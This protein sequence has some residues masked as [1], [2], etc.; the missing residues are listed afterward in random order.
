[1][2]L[3]DAREG[4]YSHSAK[5]SDV[6]RQLAFAGIAIVWIYKKD[7][8][9]TPTIDGSFIPATRWLICALGADLLQYVSASIAWGVFARWKEKQ[10]GVDE[11]TEFSAPPLL[12]WPGIVFF[13]M[14][15][16]CLLIA[17]VALSGQLWGVFHGTE[18][19][20]ATNGGAAATTS[21][22]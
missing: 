15:L 16:A 8:H 14:K 1:M 5:A 21:V 10:V 12:N 6:A 20:P 17:Y 3:S 18:K 19:A 22:H 2:K 4:Y 7:V 13:W 11:T 9:G